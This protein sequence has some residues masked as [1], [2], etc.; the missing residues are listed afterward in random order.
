MLDR[1]HFSPGEIDG[2]LGNVTLSM[3]RFFQSQDGR[4]G[5]GEAD[6]ST[7]QALRNGQLNAP[8]LIVYTVAYDDVRGPFSSVPKNIML[9]AKLKFAGYQSAFEALGEKFHCSPMLLRSLN[10]DKRLV[11]PGDQIVVPNV[12]RDQAPKAVS[13]IVSKSL[14]IVE[15]LDANGK[16]LAAYPATMGSVHDPLPIG[17][18]KVTKVFWNPVFYYNPKLFWDARPSDAKAQ[19]PPG[20]N[21]PVGAVWIGL[22][23]EHYGLHGTPEPATIGHVESHG[24]V[25]LTNW[26]AIE[27]GQMVDSG[28]PVWFRE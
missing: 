24:C 28:T 2:S 14:K 19:I 11:K 1:A 15:A 7:L 16:V 5:G 13:V 12:H 9:Q 10:P 23:K 3:L 6:D 21:N 25:R 4:A 18:W 22:N 8:M 26:D 20:P 17:E 27:L